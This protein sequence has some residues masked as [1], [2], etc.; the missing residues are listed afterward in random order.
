MMWVYNRILENGLGVKPPA[1][2]GR[3]GIG[4]MDLGEKVY[5]NVR[6][7]EKDSRRNEKDC[8]KTE[9]LWCW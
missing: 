8:G 2:Q 6:E 4:N 5:V 1:S 7:N 9:R 3:S